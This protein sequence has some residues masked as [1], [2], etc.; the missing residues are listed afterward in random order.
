MPKR[1]AMKEKR[2]LRSAALGKA[3]GRPRMAC[4]IPRAVPSER[5]P[6]RP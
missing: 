4:P 3:S 1:N 5:L 2:A 6:S